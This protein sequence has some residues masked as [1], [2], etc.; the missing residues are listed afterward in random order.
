MSAP[1]LFAAAQCNMMDAALYDYAAM[2]HERVFA[3]KGSNA[4]PPG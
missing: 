1:A 2:L 3:A 4:E